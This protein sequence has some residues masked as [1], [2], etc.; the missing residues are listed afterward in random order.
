MICVSPALQQHWQVRDLVALFSSWIEE[1]KS[2]EPVLH[3]FPVE[4]WVIALP[5]LCK[6]AETFQEQFN[7][8]NTCNIIFP[9][10]KIQS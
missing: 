5:K 6:T 2:N 10:I 3:S 7:K 8:G 1:N 9:N 4:Q